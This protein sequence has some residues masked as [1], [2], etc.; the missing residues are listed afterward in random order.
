M[1]TKSITPDP[2]LAWIVGLLEKNNIEYLADSGT[3]LGLVRDGQLMPWDKDIDITVFDSDIDKMSGLLKEAKQANYTTK[4][5][6]WRGT[7]KSYSIAPNNFFHNIT[8][9]WIPRHRLAGNRVVSLTVL[10]RKGDIYWG[11]VLYAVGSERSGLSYYAFQLLRATIVIPC[12]ILPRNRFTKALFYRNDRNIRMYRTGTHIVPVHF[13][14]ST[15][16]VMGVRAPGKATEYLRFRYGDWERPVESWS[17]MRDD[18]SFKMQ[19][20]ETLGLV[21]GEKNFNSAMPPQ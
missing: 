21:S 15:S 1:T 4:V 12:R 11:P 2:Q 3:L 13:F 19:S 20:P 16:R 10:W 5:N 14:E 6:Y 8:Y 9:P 17:Y 18:P 7:P